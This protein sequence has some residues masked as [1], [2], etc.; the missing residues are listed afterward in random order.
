MV[1]MY[2][3][4]LSDI[5]MWYSDVVLLCYYYCVILLFVFSLSLCLYRITEVVVDVVDVVVLGVGVTD[6]ASVGVIRVDVYVFVCIVDVVT[7]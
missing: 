3:M 2:L 4:M 6:V 7:S 1:L 5:M